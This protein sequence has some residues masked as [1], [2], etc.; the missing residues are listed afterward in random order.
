MPLFVSYARPDRP[1]VDSLVTRLRQAGIEV[2]LDSDL[3]G[4]WPWWDKIL[5]QI[6]DCDAV[7][8]A[9]S[10]ASIHSPACRSECE[11]AVK[12]RKPILPITLELVPSGLFPREIARIQV[13]DYTRPDEA[14]AF[15]LATAIFGL[16]K[17]AALPNPL[18][19]SPPMPPTRFGDLNDRISAPSLSLQDQLGILGM[20]EAGLAPSSDPDDRQT[21]AEMLDEM[22]RRQDLY[23]VAA[24]KLQALQAQARGG[25]QQAGQRSA[26]DSAWWS[27]APPRTE[28]PRTETPRTETPRTQAPRTQAPRTETPRKQPPKKQPPSTPPRTAPRTAPPQP[29]RY[30]SA[31]GVKTHRGMAIT[32]A[33]LTFPLV[34]LAPVGVAALIFSSRVKSSLAAGDFAAARKASSRVTIAFWISIAIWVIL[35]IYSIGLANSNSNTGSTG[36]AM[37]SQSIR[38]GEISGF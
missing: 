23:E 32:S 19:P 30:T 21:A 6:R 29:Q 27:A 15:K 34:F 20:L 5:G 14:S 4:G 33:I 26:Q 22:A 16:P 25:G 17:P 2:W 12:L 9:V 38:P 13:I 28:T 36:T 8:A 37:I 10:R 31:T 18:P 7:V 11:Y 24:R 35:I 1:R 3:I